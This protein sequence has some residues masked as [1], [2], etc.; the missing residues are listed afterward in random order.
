[1][2]GEKRWP[3]GN[4]HIFK[5]IVKKEIDLLTQE[6]NSPVKKLPINGLSAHNHIG[7]LV[8]EVSELRAEIESLK[9]Q[10]REPRKAYE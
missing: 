6:M 3:E 4:S 9:M 8:R 1:M 7:V 5:E 2:N 10:I